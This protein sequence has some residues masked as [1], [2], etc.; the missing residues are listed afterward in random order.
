MPTNLTSSFYALETPF[1]LYDYQSA[2]GMR[3]R[4][5]STGHVTNHSCRS[6][7]YSPQCMGSTYNFHKPCSC[8]TKCPCDSNLV[9]PLF[10][11]FLTAP[12][13][14]SNKSSMKKPE[15]KKKCSTPK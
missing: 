9:S 13:T 5:P 12:Y 14:Q 6:Q 2:Q 1:S 4:P 3:R 11:K 8:N 7:P 10:K 15:I